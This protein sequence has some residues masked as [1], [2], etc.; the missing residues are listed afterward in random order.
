MTDFRPLL[1]HPGDPPMFPDPNGADALGIVAVSGDL[2]PERLLTA[3]RRG[4]FPWYDDDLP[5]WW[6]PDPRAIMDPEHLRISKSLRREL[7]RTPWT[8]TWDRDFEQVITACGERPEGT[9]IHREMVAA[10]LRL[11]GIGHAHSL[12][13]WAGTDLVGGLYGV[14]CGGLFAAESMF[15][16]RTNASKVALVCA[17]LDLFAVGV[18]VFDVQFMTSHLES[19]GAYQIPRADYLGR[20]PAATR[21]VVDGSALPERNPL[22]EVRMRLPTSS[23]HPSNG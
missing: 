10:Y 3:Y 22:T 15:H 18:R 5:L 2:S 6:S 17:V 4:V 23:G 19:M 21:R 11:H 16:R 14:L 1:I 13:V 7:R 9:W 12:E 8:V 20:L